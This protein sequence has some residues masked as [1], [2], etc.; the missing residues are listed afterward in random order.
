MIYLFITLGKFLEVELLMIT[1]NLWNTIEDICRYLDLLKA[2]LGLEEFIILLKI[3]RNHGKEWSFFITPGVTEPCLRN[4]SW[5][6]TL[7][8]LLL[9]LIGSPT[10]SVHSM[11]VM[12][13]WVLPMFLPWNKGWT[14]NIVCKQ[15][16]FILLAYSR[17]TEF[18]TTQGSVL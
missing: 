16:V 13:I 14:I 5:E 9:A 1:A 4:H 17:E 15:N 11:G 8:N 3:M 7:E 6:D 2:R 18:Y 10:I 12:F